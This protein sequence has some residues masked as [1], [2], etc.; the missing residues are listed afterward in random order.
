MAGSGTSPADEAAGQERSF[1]GFSLAGLHGEV[2]AAHR[3]V[4]LS[5]AIELLVDPGRG[6]ETLHWGRNYLYSS[7]LETLTGPI[8]VVV[9]QFRNQ[10]FRARLSRRLKGS[11]AKRSWRAAQAVVD[12]GVPTPAPVLL[13]E[14]EAANGPSFF[15]S[16]K[17]PDSIEARY[18]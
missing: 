2:S 16:E 17:I 3:P 13:I 5:D 14:S 1:E 12:A 8:S 9:K 18:F 6:G 7:E 4:D 10:G 11:K 15:V